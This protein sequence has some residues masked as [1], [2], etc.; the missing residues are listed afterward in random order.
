VSL[1]VMVATL[2]APTASAAS[3]RRT[4]QAQLAAGGGSG[5]ATLTAYWAGNGALGLALKGLQPSAK[6][7]IIVYRGTCAAP[8]RIASLPAAATDASGAVATTSPVSTGVMNSIWTY[9]RTAS[10]AIK[11][12]TGSQALCGGL[13]FAVATRI[14]IIGLK[15]DLPIIKPTSAYPPCNVALYL[16]ELSQP[17]EAGVTFIYAHARKGMFLPLLERSKINNGASLLGMT[18]KVWTS[19][20]L[21]TTYKITKVRRHVT[22]LGNALDLETEQLWIQTSEGPR[23]T[24]GKLIVLAKRIAVE[25]ATHEAAHPTARPVTCG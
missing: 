3:V 7:P 24:V 9:A 19:N 13:R 15:I 23:G 20:N 12:G 21:V 16:R 8:I 5:T 14:A 2:V 17:G 22:T 18:V 6:Y 1:A 11:V 25:P 4:W 10:V